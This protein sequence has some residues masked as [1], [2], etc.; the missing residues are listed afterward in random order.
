M[1]L[2]SDTKPPHS[3]GSFLSALLALVEIQLP[4]WKSLKALVVLFAAAAAVHIEPGY[5][6]IITTWLTRLPW[7]GAFSQPARTLPSLFDL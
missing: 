2:N 7:H 6:G 4:L 5:V 1:R 3:L